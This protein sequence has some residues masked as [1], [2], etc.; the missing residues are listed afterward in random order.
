MRSVKPQGM[1]L[2][3][4]AKNNPFRSYYDFEIC[5]GAEGLKLAL[6]ALNRNGYELVAVT[7]TMDKYTV[8]FRR[9]AV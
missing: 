8:F 7:Q 6:S 1:L 5:Y 4:A 9:P 3:E 2:M